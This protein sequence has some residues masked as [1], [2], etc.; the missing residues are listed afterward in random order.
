MKKVGTIFTVFCVILVVAIILL[1]ALAAFT[2]WLSGLGDPE[3]TTDFDMDAFLATKQ[4]NFVYG[5]IFIVFIFL[6]MAA[7]LILITRTLFSRFFMLVVNAAQICLQSVVFLPNILR[8]SIWEMHYSILLLFLFFLIPVAAN[9]TMLW[10]MIKLIKQ[11][12]AIK[13]EKPALPDKS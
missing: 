9:G 13:K 1:N 11:Q 8:S 7:G 10:M 4:R 6:T 3:I 5:W 12:K 2:L